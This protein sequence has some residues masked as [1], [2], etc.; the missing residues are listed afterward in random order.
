ME[1]IKKEKVQ[2][3][4]LVISLII[5]AAILQLISIKF[6]GT[7]SLNVLKPVAAADSIQMVIL[8]SN[9]SD[10]SLKGRTLKNQFLIC[11]KIKDYN[12]GIAI[13]YYVN[14]YAFSLC[15][16][17]FITLLTI[18]VFL[19]A[20]KGWQN[21]SILL[22]TFLLTTIVLAS[23]YYFLPNVLN[24]KENFQKNTD[25]VKAFQKIQ[26]D[27]LAFAGTINQVS[28]AKIDSTLNSNY[29]QITT[30]FDFISTIDAS[31]LNSNPQDLLKT[32]KP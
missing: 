16:I 31:K 10:T 27:I 30:N 28:Q 25:K 23:I 3:L 4:V 29:N 15:S 6:M 14:Y 11:Q 1:F 18:A 17:L 2:A 20:N 7:A 24:N 21:T 22:K 13:S 19:V 26:F 32:I 9:I 8:N 12:K 5:M